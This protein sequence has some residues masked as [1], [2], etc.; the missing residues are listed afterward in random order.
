MVQVLMGGTRQSMESSTGWVFAV[1]WPDSEAS[2]V[3]GC[4]VGLAQER[5]VDGGQD[6][7]LV[8]RIAGA[9]HESNNSLFFS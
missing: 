7:R 9:S 2:D 6:L 4:S 3:A 8:H 5:A 1:D